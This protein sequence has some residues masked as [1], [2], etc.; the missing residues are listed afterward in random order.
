MFPTSRW[1]SSSFLGGESQKSNQFGRQNTTSTPALPPYS[2]WNNRPERIINP[3]ALE[4][5][6]KYHQKT[7][8]IQELLKLW[9][10]ENQIDIKR[11]EK[12]ADK[13]CRTYHRSRKDMGSSQIQSQMKPGA[14]KDTQANPNENNGSPW[15]RHSLPLTCL[16]EGSLLCTS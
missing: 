7:R 3:K 11:R 16:C 6:K 2:P 12:N 15:Q 14:K 4:N 8:I 9:S 1:H 5:N 13:M 10:N